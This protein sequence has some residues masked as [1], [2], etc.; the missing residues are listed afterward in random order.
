MW[1]LTS[2]MTS[3]KRVGKYERKMGFF[4]KQKSNQIDKKEYF[5]SEIENFE[6]KA[7]LVRLF[8]REIS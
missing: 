4:D 6:L 5:S 1:N 7:T 8:R 3:L 2:F